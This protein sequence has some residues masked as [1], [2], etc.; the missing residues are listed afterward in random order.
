[1]SGIFVFLFFKYIK[2]SLN[3][4]PAYCLLFNLP[5]QKQKQISFLLLWQIIIKTEVSFHLGLCGCCRIDIKNEK[6]E[7]KGKIIEPRST[8]QFGIP[9]QRWPSALE[10]TNNIKHSVSISRKMHFERCPEAT[11]PSYCTKV[12]LGCQ[13]CAGCFAWVNWS[14]KRTRLTDSFWDHWGVHMFPG[15]LRVNNQCTL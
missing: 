8:I 10:K 3:T 4:L 1:M 13:K 12:K 2:I 15:S 6:Q 5:H 7:K 11:Q 14:R 9:A